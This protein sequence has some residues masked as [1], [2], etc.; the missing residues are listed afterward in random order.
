MK[1]LNIS[2][3]LVTDIKGGTTPHEKFNIS[4]IIVTDIKGAPPL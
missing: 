1:N 3:I 2:Y 4:Y